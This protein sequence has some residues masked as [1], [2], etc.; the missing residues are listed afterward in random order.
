V[1]ISTS[2][3]PV[4]PVQI[5]SLNVTNITPVK[6]NGSTGS[7]FMNNIRLQNNELIGIITYYGFL[8]IAVASYRYSSQLWSSTLFLSFA[9]LS[10][11]L[12]FSDYIVLPFSIG[13]IILGFIFKRLNI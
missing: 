9:T 5:A 6:Y 3:L 13:A 2:P 8:A 10:I 11:G 4:K 1:T 7:S 12:L